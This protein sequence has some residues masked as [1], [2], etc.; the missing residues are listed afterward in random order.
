MGG[1]D[2]WGN[3]VSG[4]DLGRRSGTK[5]LYAVT[6]PLLA[7]SSGAR[8][9]KTADGAVW[10]S[11]EMLSPYDYWQYWRNCEDADVSRF[12]K[13][14]TPLPLDEIDKLGALEGAQMNEAK[15]ILATE[16]TAMVH[17][18]EAAEMAAETA[19]KTFEEGVTAQSLPTIK[20][21][22]SQIDDGIGLLTLIVE[23]G[24]ASSNGEARRHIKGGSIK[25][26][27]IAMK[28]ERANVDST[29]LNDDGV[30]KLSMGKKKHVLVKPA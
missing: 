10:L 18:R 22:Q 6:T 4:V 25:I 19:R 29:H 14:F 23:A 21:P 7:T 20:I 5:E 13:L 9:G 27:D 12:L 26:N 17:G 3:I 8:M 24:F 11:P 30:I 2:Q 28:D 16:T 1:S 15:K